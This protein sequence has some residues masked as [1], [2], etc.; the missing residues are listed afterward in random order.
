MPILYISIVARRMVYPRPREPSKASSWSLRYVQPPRR[1]RKPPRR[2]RKPPR[3]VSGGALEA[4]RSLL[5]DTLREGFAKAP[6]APPFGNVSSDDNDKPPPNPVFEIVLESVK[7]CTTGM[8]S[9]TLYAQHPA[10]LRIF[11]SLLGSPPTSFYPDANSVLLRAPLF[12][13]RL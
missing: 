10:S 3:R 2:V 12:S 1:V 4:P 7:V 5:E 6:R 11:P 8:S 13:S 9:R